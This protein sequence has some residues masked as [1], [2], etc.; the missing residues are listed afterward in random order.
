MFRAQTLQLLLG[1]NAITACAVPPT[2]PDILALPPEGKDLTQFQQEDITCRIYAE[3]QVGYGVQKQ[4]ASDSTTGSTTAGTPAGTTA[5]STIGDSAGTEA[6]AEAGAGPLAGFALGTN[7]S[8]S[9]AVLQQR[10]DFAYAQCMA[11]TGNLVQPF[12]LA[13]LYAR[14]AYPYWAYYDPWLGSPFAFGFF[15]RVGPRFHHHIFIHHGVHR[16]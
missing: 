16:G 7:A 11:A 8:A 2:G 6:V 13:W 5:G 15:G 14:Y 4:A 12:P 1:L 10:Y 9:T 3:R